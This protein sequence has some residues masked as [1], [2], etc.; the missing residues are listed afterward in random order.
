MYFGETSWS[1]RC[2]SWRRTN[3][4]RARVNRRDKLKCLKEL[5]NNLR[6]NQSSWQQQSVNFHVRSPSP[7][8]HL[9]LAPFFVRA[10]SNP[11]W[12]NRINLSSNSSRSACFIITEHSAILILTGGKSCTAES[13]EDISFSRWKTT[14]CLA[15]LATLERNKAPFVISC[16]CSSW[17]GCL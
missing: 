2:T 10:V 8:F 4:A 11:T 12:S 14:A 16:A 15:V 6:K 13:S 5:C 3:Y 1:M 7:P 9:H 17:M